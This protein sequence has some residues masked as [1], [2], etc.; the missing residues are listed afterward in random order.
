MDLKED[1]HPIWHFKK[2]KYFLGSL[3][4]SSWCHFGYLKNGETQIWNQLKQTHVIV[5]GS[6]LDFSKEEQGETLM[7][8]ASSPM[9]KSDCYCLKLFLGF[10]LICYFSQFAL[11]SWRKLD[12]QP[13]HQKGKYHPYPHVHNYQENSWRQSSKYKKKSL[14]RKSNRPKLDIYTLILSKNWDK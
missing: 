5:E 7:L 2:G 1:V 14:I 3:L 9:Q 12:M 4:L 10:F 8:S 13:W 6:T 11:I